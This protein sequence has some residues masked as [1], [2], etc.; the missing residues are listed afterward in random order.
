MSN[1]EHAGYLLG[2]SDDERQRLHDLLESF[3]QKRLLE[4]V[5]TGQHVL[6]VGCGPGAVSAALGQAVGPTGSVIGVDMQAAQLV[7]AAEYCEEQGLENVTFQPADATALPFE[8]DRF[9][10]VYA[11]FLLLH[12]PDP[13]AGLLDMIRVLK[14]GGTLFI[15]DVD[16]GAVLFYPEGTPAHRAWQLGMKVLEA[17][18]AD[19]RIGRKLYSMFRRAHMENIKV[20]PEMAA[21]SVEQRRLLKGAKRQFAGLLESL[22]DRVIDGGHATHDELKELIMELISDYSDEFLTTCGINCWGTKPA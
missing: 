3:G 17:G 8:A 6:D 20:I 18:G 16:A 5:R 10:L 11:K 22:R 9:D 19:P 21:A 13:V 12:L 2:S 7:S 15:H 14:P 1:S 4:V